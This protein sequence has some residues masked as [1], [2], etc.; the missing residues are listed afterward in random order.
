MSDPETLVVNVVAAPTA[1]DLEAEGAGEVGEGEAEAPAEGEEDA[2]G[3]GG[4]GA[5][6]KKIPPNNFLLLACAVYRRPLTT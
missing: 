2:E 1:E 4:E 3:G 5:A 6:P